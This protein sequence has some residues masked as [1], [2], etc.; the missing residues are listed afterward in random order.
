M[1][2][3]AGLLRPGA[4]VAEST[5]DVTSLFSVFRNGETATLPPA[6]TASPTDNGT[7]PSV[8]SSGV[9]DF[10]RAHRLGSH[11]GPFDSDLFLFPR[12]DKQSIC[13]ALIG[14]KESDVAMEDCYHPTGP[15][16][17]DALGG[18]HFGISAPESVVA[19]GSVIQVFGVAFDD[20]EAFRVEVGSDW[21]DVPIVGKNGF[22][23]SLTN[24]SREDLGHFEATLADGTVQVHDTQTNRRV[25]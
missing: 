1:A 9:A 6:I 7:D 3:G 11:L 23:L 2:T 15:A 8:P 19:D 17:F 24:V 21:R 22:Y 20:V 25:R 4:S 12:R 18:E 14:A 10:S 13:Y 5:T 16:A